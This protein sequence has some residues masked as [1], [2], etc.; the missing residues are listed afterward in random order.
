M[1]PTAGDETHEETRY[2][3]LSEVLHTAHH[4][5]YYEWEKYWQ[6]TRHGAK[7]HVLKEHAVKSIFFDPLIY[8]PKQEGTTTVPQYV[9]TFS[10]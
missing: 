5:A 3:E 6:T 10:L 4:V 8:A 1:N 7:A 2:A 9:L